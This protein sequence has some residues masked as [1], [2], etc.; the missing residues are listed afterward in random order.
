MIDPSAYPHLAAFFRAY[1]HEDFIAEHGSAPQAFAA[2]RAD[3]PPVE[4]AAL[5]AERARLGEAL[6][7]LS[8]AEIRRVIREE[9][10]SAWNPAS[11]A[12]VLALLRS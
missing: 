10:R 4:R 1:L 9:L 6:Q 2:F 3:L 11:R 8:L 7:H 5:D 12:E